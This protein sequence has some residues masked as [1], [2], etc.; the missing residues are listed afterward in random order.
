V[1][2]EEQHREYDL[3]ECADSAGNDEAADG[4][5]ARNWSDVS[6]AEAQL[7]PRMSQAELKKFSELRAAYDASCGVLIKTIGEKAKISS[8]CGADW[9]RLSDASSAM[10]LRGGEKRALDVLNQSP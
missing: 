4:V 1:L 8:M 9:T 3:K 6:P 10:Q 7:G 2:A 5:C